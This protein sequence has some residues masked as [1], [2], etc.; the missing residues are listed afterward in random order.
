MFQFVEPIAFDHLADPCHQPDEEKIWLLFVALHLVCNV[1]LLRRI[2]VGDKPQRY[3]RMCCYWMP[4]YRGER[5]RTQGS[6][7]RRRAPFS[8]QFVK[9]IVFDCL[10]NPFHQPYQEAQVVDRGKPVEGE[11]A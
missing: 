6:T 3:E 1:K 11:L 7:L 10:A 8:F 5:R 9:P 4:Y 2:N